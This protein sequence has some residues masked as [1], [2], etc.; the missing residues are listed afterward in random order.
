MSVLVIENQELSKE[1]T[2]FQTP[3]PVKS[4]SDSDGVIECLKQQI[5][6]LLKE[7]E[8]ISHLWQNAT[9]SVEILEGELSIFQSGNENF[10]PKNDLLKVKRVFTRN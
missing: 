7:K 1:L 4:S 8:H 6:H 3:Q 5:R 10:V 9:K 2:K